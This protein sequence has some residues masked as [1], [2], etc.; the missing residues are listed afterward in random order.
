[1]A[2]FQ[3]LK[4]FRDFFP[5]EMAAR[6]VVMDKIFCVVRR[7]GFR[8]VDTPSVESL[9]LF[10]V[11]SGEEICQQTFSFK[12]KAD[13]EITLIPELTPTVARMVVERAKT[14]RLPI[15]WFSMP[16]MWRY[17]EP[18]SGR[19]R[20][21]YQLNA[22]IYGVKGPEADAEV[23]AVGIDLM[24]GLGLAG[25]FIF[26]ISDRRLMQGILEGM[27]FTNPGPIFAAI[28]KRG[29]ITGEEFKKMLFDAGMDDFQVGELEA[30]LET[31]GPMAE[32]LP[33][34][35]NAAAKYVESPGA[36]E[37]LE[38]LEKLSQLLTMYNMVQFCELDPSIIR[39]LAYYTATVFECFDVKGEL[40]AIFGGGRYDK[41]VELFGGEPMPAVGFGM[42]DAVLE[43][44]MRRAG[45]WPEETICSD[46]YILITK[47]EF[48]ETEMFVAQSLREKGFVVEFDLQGRNFSNQMKYANSIG[49]RNVLILGEREMA[50]GKVTV[51]DMESGEQKTVE[52][53]EFLNSTKP[54]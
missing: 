27:G 10:K 5:E 37:G 39:G 53:L 12:D 1:M 51:K 52:V 36:K 20:E 6:R 54:C 45:V 17:E 47:P 49:A 33:L 25:E 13:R 2:K 44:L 16:K 29:K 50:E 26:K 8:E 24:L 32:A 41:I 48:K 35:R 43:L 19:L 4:G 34:L 18:Q 30:I 42:G 11:K 7:Y 3:S 21:F 15:K 14:L 22:D 23:L 46:Y 40:R 9:E 31:R 28:D 38:N